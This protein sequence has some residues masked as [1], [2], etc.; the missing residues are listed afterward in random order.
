MN[1]NGVH[2]MKKLQIT[3]SFFEIPQKKNIIVFKRKEMEV[4]ENFVDFRHG[5]S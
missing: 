5:N 2:D 1:Y 3:F 4:M